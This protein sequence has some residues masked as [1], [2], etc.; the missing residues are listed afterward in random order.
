MKFCSQQNNHRTDNPCDPCAIR[1][2]EQGG[3]ERTG[4]S[5]P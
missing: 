2:L 4:R 5:K 1:D 3:N